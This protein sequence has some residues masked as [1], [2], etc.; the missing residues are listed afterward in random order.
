MA[1]Y[2]F[3]VIVDRVQRQGEIGVNFLAGA[4]RHELIENQP[5]ARRQLRDFV[6]SGT[7]CAGL[8]QPRNFGEKDVSEARFPRRKRRG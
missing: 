6:G 2:L 1:E 5:T 4:A 3:Y 7:W 8:V